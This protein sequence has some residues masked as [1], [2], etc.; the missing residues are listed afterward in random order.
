MDPTFGTEKFVNPLYVVLILAAL[1]IGIT[2][3]FVWL[4][5]EWHAEYNE[6]MQP[7]AN[8]GPQNTHESRIITAGASGGLGSE[9]YDAAT[10][11]VGNL[12]DVTP[13]VP[14]PVERVYKNPF[15]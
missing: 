13:P 9:L 8:I 1:F 11:P 15:E 4:G 5:N 14:N 3:L 12:P 10:N 2:G 7:T 6:L